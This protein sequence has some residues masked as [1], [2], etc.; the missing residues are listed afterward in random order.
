MNRQHS[1]IPPSW[2]NGKGKEIVE[3][4]SKGRGGKKGGEM[5][6]CV[7][8]FASLF[9]GGIVTPVHLEALKLSVN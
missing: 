6:K 5:V 4:G 3:R 8:E 1:T 9:L 7:G 2:I